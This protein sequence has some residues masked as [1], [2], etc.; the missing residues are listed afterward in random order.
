MSLVDKDVP[1]GGTSVGNPQRTHR[2]HFKAHAILNRMVAE[3]DRK[4]EKE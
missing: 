2:D 1:A 4:K 3:R